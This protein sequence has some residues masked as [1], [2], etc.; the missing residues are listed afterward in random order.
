MSL[1][2][3]EEMELL[4]PYPLS[5]EIWGEHIHEG[6]KPPSF[7]KFDRRSDPFEHVASII[8]QM[9]IIEALDSMK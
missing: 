9:T 1:I 8:T 5:D 6:F 3:L 2:P 7:A 4:D